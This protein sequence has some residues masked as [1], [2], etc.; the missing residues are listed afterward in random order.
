MR[1]LFISNLYPPNVVGGY[2]QLCFEVADALAM[3]GHH[4]SVL[5]SDYGGG[6]AQYAGQSVYRSLRL[7]AGREIYEPF[8]GDAADR[9][10]VNRS[11]LQALRDAVAEVAPD[12]IFAWNLFFLDRSF[13]AAL[14]ECRQPVVLM[15]TDNWLLSLERPEYMSRFFR[16]HVFGPAPFPLPP[17]APPPSAHVPAWWERLIRR[18]HLGLTDAPL[19]APLRFR[20][21]AVF[22][23][24]FVREMHTDAGLSFASDRVVHNGVR[25]KQHSEAAAWDRARRAHEPELRLLFAGRLVDLKGAHDLVAAVPLLTTAEPGLGT[26]RLTLLGDARDAKYME[27]LRRDIAASRCA[28]RIEIRPP[29][30][31]DSLPGLFREHDIYVFPSLY[32]PFSLTLIHALASGIPT[33]AS[34]AGGNVEIICD[35]VSGVLFNKGDPSD[36]A[37]AVLRLANDPALRTAV[38]LGGREAA[39]RFTFENMVNGMEDFLREMTA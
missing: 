33:A 32:E 15:L 4:V 5:A 13:V 16:E 8:P 22:G 23:A 14:A 12:V 36:L 18:P 7:L 19:P 21:A 29:V 38:A 17:V 11:N 1:V 37:R 26:L 34:R 24:S 10:A 35:G 27:R 2:E 28:Y 9:D 20:F 6:T 25:Q 31:E 39:A 3:H 30:A